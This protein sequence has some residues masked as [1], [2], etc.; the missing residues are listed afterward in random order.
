[1]KSL[2]GFCTNFIFELACEVYTTK[3][4]FPIILC[5]KMDSLWNLGEM[6]KLVIL[7]NPWHPKK[8]YG[9]LR[10][11]LLLIVVDLDMYK[12]SYIIFGTIYK[13]SV[14]I[15]KIGQTQWVLRYFGPKIYKIHSETKPWPQESLKSDL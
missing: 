15:F 9:R 3:T 13:P 4:Y 14:P 5:V 11:E 12:P 10:D 2:L 1:M 7:G 8:V 6:I